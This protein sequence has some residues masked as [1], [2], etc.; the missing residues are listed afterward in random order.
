[1]PSPQPKVVPLADRR[2]GDRP[3]VARR[4]RVVVADDDEDVRETI[5]RMLE[6]DGF[7][8]LTA[9]DGAALARLIDDALATGHPPDLLVLD[10]RMPCSTGLEV[11]A[12]V[13]A[14]GF[15]KP[16]VL[17]TAFSELSPRARALGAELLEKPFEP[18]HLR[19]WVFDRVGY[20]HRTL[21]PHDRADREAAVVRCVSCGVGERVV[22]DDARR[23]PP[24]WFCLECRARAHPLPG[25]ELGEGD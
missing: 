1:M 17:I 25:D 4:P 15:T 10:Q 5:A 6:C 14:R 19:R 22:D 11:L 3:A 24:T 20:P 12:E 2:R 8:V 23:N 16:A 9:A 18:D 21:D 13:R 7:E